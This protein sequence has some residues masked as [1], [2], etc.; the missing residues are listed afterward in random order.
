MHNCLRLH[1]L[2]LNLDFGVFRES[3]KSHTVFN[4]IEFG[5]SFEPL[6][7]ESK[8]QMEEGT[9]NKGA[10]R[11]NKEIKKSQNMYTKMFAMIY[12]TLSLNCVA[13]VKA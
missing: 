9:A 7:R 2:L 3:T 13:H 10:E 8:I 12:G 11:N 6:N 1:F 4:S 5:L